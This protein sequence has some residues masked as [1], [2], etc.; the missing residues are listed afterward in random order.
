M[1][2]ILRLHAFFFFPR[3]ALIKGNPDESFDSLLISPF[4]TTSLQRMRFMLCETGG[5]KK[6]LANNWHMD[7]GGGEKTDRTHY[8]NAAHNI[9]FAMFISRA[10]GVLIWTVYM[11]GSHYKTQVPFFPFPVYNIRYK[12][13]TRRT[14]GCFEKKKLIRDDNDIENY[15]GNCHHLFFV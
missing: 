14:C 13:G 15:S 8:E 7:S 1:C 3:D 6:G 4:L 12:V 5:L 11:R 9:S 2:K 10:G